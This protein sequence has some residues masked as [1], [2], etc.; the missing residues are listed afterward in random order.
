MGCIFQEELQSTND[1][2][3]NARKSINEEKS[4]RAVA[5]DKLRKLQEGLRL[6]EEEIRLLEEDKKE[7]LHEIASLEE[8]VCCLCKQ[9]FVCYESSCN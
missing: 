3:K 8:K 9:V 7:K 2:L 6:Q 5:E 4:L 1:E